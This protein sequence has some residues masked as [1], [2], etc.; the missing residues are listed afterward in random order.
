MKVFNSIILDDLKGGGNKGI[1]EI[2]FGN[3]IFSRTKLCLIW[4]FLVG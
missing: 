1:L 4:K 3:G 2:C